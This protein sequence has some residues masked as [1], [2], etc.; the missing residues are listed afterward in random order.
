MIRLGTSDLRVH[1]L[2]LGGNV[3]GWT[4]D[5][6]AAF[7]VLDAYADAGGNFV[8]TADSYPKWAPGNSG[9]ESEEIIG[10]WSSARGNRD[11][12]VIATKVGAHPEFRGLRSRNIRA[13]VEQSL[14][15][16]RRDHIDLYYTHNDDPDVPVEEFLGA[17]TELVTDGKVR[18]IGASN[19]TAARLTR[20]LSAADRDGLVRYVVL[21]HH[22]N[23]MERARYEGALADVVAA[24]GLASVPYYA[25][26]SGFLT[27]K[28]RHG[29][30]IDSPRSATASAYL[31]SPCGVPVLEA[32]DIVADAHGSTPTAVALAWLAAQ[33]TVTVPIASARDTAQLAEQLAYLDLTLDKTEIQF[34]TAASENPPA[35][36]R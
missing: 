3:F 27:G 11:R 7:A 4:A 15:R 36:P 31:D 13:A 20:A 10:N 17:L 1:P 2:A 22:Y 35:G 24:H 21:Q 29:T 25:L 19:I 32:L 5:Q 34:L 9:G 26:A 28:Y 23:L 16:L 12:L 30:T 8:D 14:R 33:P 6:R 18:Y